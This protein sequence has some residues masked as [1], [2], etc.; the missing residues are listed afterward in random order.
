MK[1]IL[2]ESQLKKIVKGLNNDWKEVDGK[3]IRIYT[4]PTYKDTINFVNKVAEISTEQNHH[5]E[6]VIG[7]DTVKVIMFD[8]EKDGISDKCHKFTDAV[9]KMVENE[10]SLDEASR[11]FAFTRKKRLFPKSAMMANPNRFKK[12]DKEVKGIE[13]EL[14]DSPIENDIQES[15]DVC[16]QE[17]LDTLNDFLSGIVTLGPEDIG[18]E[19]SH[20]DLLSSVTDPKQK[21][22]LSKVLINISQMN[23]D[24]LRVELI[25]VMSMKNLKEQPTPYLD[26]TT[27]IG[28]V[29]IPTVV[30][31]GSLGLL[32]IAILT[33]MIK[34]IGNLDVNSKDKRRRK[35]DRIARRAIGCRGGRFRDRLVRMRRRRESWKSFLSKIGLR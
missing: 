10:E 8:H 34:G 31:H 14:G 13:K 22:I 15:E 28:G 6:M 18:G 24:P 35:Y 1:I 23:M 25:K 9:D 29:Q 11:S 2:T 4:F 16:F 21:N 26:R 30:V 17:E 12:Y 19:L 3:L 7:H 32:A 20:E 5:P 33:R 27:E